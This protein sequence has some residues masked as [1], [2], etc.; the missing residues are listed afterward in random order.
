MTRL[1]VSVRSADEAAVALEAG[2]DLIDV[3][4]P[5]RGPM[6]AADAQVIVDVVRRVAGRAPVSAAL[7][8][9]GDPPTRRE[10][11]EGRRDAIAGLALAKLGLAGA[12][13]VYDW[14]SRWGRHVARLPTLTAPVAVAYADWTQARAVHPYAV[15]SGGA[16]L[17]CAAVLVDTFDKSSGSLVERWT[18]DQLAQFVISARALGLVVV[19]AG[20][21]SLETLSD[22]LRLEPDYVAVRGAACRD[23]RGGTIDADRVRRLSDLCRDY[24]AA[25]RSS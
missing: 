19:L 6:G 25:R 17:G 1:L 14:P 5:A 10:A 21:L 11:I 12:A 18:L 13:D 16:A 24:S 3:K 20:S 2:A 22:V 8:D 15:L 4:E 9:V 23:G 7:G